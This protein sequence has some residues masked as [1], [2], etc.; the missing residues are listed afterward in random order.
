M[1]L[2]P[3]KVKYILPALFFLFFL[4]ALI[5]VTQNQ[6]TLSP[7]EVKEGW[8]VFYQK[9][10]FEC[11]SIWDKGGKVGPEL[12]ESVGEIYSVTQLAGVF[13]NHAPEMW[14]RMGEERMASFRIEEE[15][16]ANLFTFLYFIR[17]ID[18]PGD[19]HKGEKLLSE[20]KCNL[21][22]SIHG[23]RGKVG[24]DL[25]RW[26]NY[27]NPLLWAQMM[28]NHGHRMIEEMRRKDLSWPKFQKGEMNDLISYI[29][30]VSP[31]QEKLYLSLGDP[32]SGER[33]FL[34]KGCRTCH[35]IGEGKGIDLTEVR[36]F[37]TTFS[38]MAAL[39]WNHLP[40]MQSL[41]EGEKVSLTKLSAQEMA[42]LISYIFSVRYLEHQGNKKLGRKIFLD[43]K[44][45]LCHSKG[46]DSGAT[47][48]DELKGEITPVF[49]AYSMWN[50]GQIMLKKMREKELEW[51]K[52]Q[53]DEIK[54]L[55]EYLNR[56][57]K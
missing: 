2:K 40:K 19:M 39:M 43:K 41:M 38:Q 13:W 49:L 24:A 29:R 54:H 9:G 36:P 5:G 52:F 15:E 35:S 6:F 26:G 50:H 23:T 27:T 56:D 48:L 34:Q 11:H 25:S 21:C 3:I 44:C 47:D 1:S 18:Q 16:M 10:C 28:W 31:A 46:S 33:L 42:D 20:K 22:H 37:P 4:F 17:F 14:H 32:E 53:D 12:T 51:P 8:R 45:D 55:L 30:S 57:T 7:G